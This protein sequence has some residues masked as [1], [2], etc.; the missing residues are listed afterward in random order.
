[1]NRVVANS[2]RAFALAAFLPTCSDGD[3]PRSDSNAQLM[4]AS[5]GADL[6]PN[7]THPTLDAITNPGRRKF[8]EGILSDFKK[9]PFES[10]TINNSTWYDPQTLEV[11]IPLPRGITLEVDIQYPNN[12]DRNQKTTVVTYTTPS[13]NHSWPFSAYGYDVQD[14]IAYEVETWLTP[15]ISAI[16]NELSIIKRKLNAFVEDAQG[17]VKRDEIK[18]TPTED[19]NVSVGTYS[20]LG[21]DPQRVLTVTRTELFRSNTE[22][23]FSYAANAEIVVTHPLYKIASELGSCN[24]KEAWIGSSKESLIHVITS[25]LAVADL[26]TIKIEGVESKPGEPIR[27]P[28]PEIGTITLDNGLVVRIEKSNSVR[29]ELTSIAVIGIDGREYKISESVDLAVINE[30]W[31]KRLEAKRAEIEKI[32]PK[33]RDVFIADIAQGKV[34]LPHASQAGQQILSGGKD[35]FTY[36]VVR[37][38]PPAIYDTYPGRYV[39]NVF[40]EWLGERS[41]TGRELND[42]PLD[43]ACKARI[44]EALVPANQD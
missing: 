37:T 36:T 39:I 44:E 14:L 35:D 23:Y 22:G 32:L 6:A 4:T 20:I 15:K 1:M 7:K 12:S 8:A 28:T 9:T 27:I 26:S 18:F 16:R 25:G 34:T 43:T 11:K 42:S 38:G 3:A 21:Q 5:F 40:H 13:S 24:P 31:K 17:M 33:T 10:V 2:V 41:D 30:I 29:D 19:P